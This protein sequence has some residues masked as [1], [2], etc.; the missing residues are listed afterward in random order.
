MTFRFIDTAGLR[1]TNDEIE[2]LV[3]ER[4]YQKIEQAQIILW[5]VYSTQVTE[6]IE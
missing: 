4:T 1:K 3:I 2:K 6:H 5:V